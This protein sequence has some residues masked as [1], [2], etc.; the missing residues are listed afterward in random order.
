MIVD[1]FPIDDELDMLDCRLY[2]YRGLVDLFVAI[3]ADH[4]FTGE[5]KP[6]HLTEARKRG[7]FLDVPL[8]VI[9]V[10]TADPPSAGLGHKPYVFPETERFWDRDALQ[11]NAA[12]GLLANLPPD[13]VVLHGDV[14]ELVRRWVFHEPLPHPKVLLLDM[15]IYTTGL[16]HPEAWAGPVIGK[17][18]DLPALAMV[19]NNRWHFDLKVKAGWHLSWFGEPEDRIRKMRHFSHRE[20]RDRVGDRV[21]SEFPAA[22]IHVDGEGKLERYAE[23]LPDWVRDGLAPASWTREW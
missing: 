10:E 7:R 8:E 12:S 11:R 9:T 14:D 15:L 5:P 21:G 3:E 4:T 20:L 1:V 18:A 13:T 17:L 19:R 6:Y 16:R 2:Q 22:H 23:D